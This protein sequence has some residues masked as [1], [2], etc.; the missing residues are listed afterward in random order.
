MFLDHQRANAAPLLNQVLRAIPDSKGSSGIKAMVRRVH[1]V[2]A[3]AKDFESKVLGE[4]PAT[5]PAERVA[6]AEV[7]ARHRVES[8]LDTFRN[9]VTQSVETNQ[10]WH[11][12]RNTDPLFAQ[13]DALRDNIP[14]SFVA[15]VL[16]AK[17]HAFQAIVRKIDGQYSLT[18]CNRGDRPGQSVTEFVFADV[19]NLR[20]VLENS[21]PLGAQRRSVESIYSD[22]TTHCARMP[23]AGE[24]K[25]I[26]DQP[27]IYEYDYIKP[28]Q[29]TGNCVEKNAIFCLEYASR[30]RDI[31][32]LRAARAN[33]ASTRRNLTVPGL[34]THIKQKI[35]KMPE[36]ASLPRMDAA[37]EQEMKELSAELRQVS[38][39]YRQNRRFRNILEGKIKLP[40]PRPSTMEDAL[41]LA[42]S[43][44]QMP[45]ITASLNLETIKYLLEHRKVELKDWGRERCEELHL[46]TSPDVIAAI[47]NGAPVDDGSQ[48]ILDRVLASRSDHPFAFAISEFKL[49][50]ASAY[51]S[52]GMAVYKTEVDTSIAALTSAIALV[53]KS[54][55]MF[56]ARGELYAKSPAQF[57]LAK[58][59]FDVGIELTGRSIVSLCARAR[60]FAVEKKYD[61]AIADFEEA[62]EKIEQKTGYL[63]EALIDNE[64]GVKNDLVRA[65]GLRA[66]T[67]ERSGDYKSS[68]DD[69]LRLF[70]LAPSDAGIRRDIATN[71][72]RIIRQMLEEDDVDWSHVVHS[73]NVLLTV[74]P[75][76]SVSEEFPS[77]TEMLRGEYAFLGGRVRG[78]RDAKDTNP[79]P[80]I[81]SAESRLKILH[82]VCEDLKKNICPALSRYLIQILDTTT[83]REGSFGFRR[84]RLGK[85]KDAIRSVLQSL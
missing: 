67:H 73:L 49:A 69:H 75:R 64:K 22:A 78:A 65:Y 34:F 52:R 48:R 24:G 21:N 66:S 46:M 68:A 62:V 55:G 41:Q 44:K 10:A 35:M 8:N 77:F 79:R 31:A 27:Q 39:I 2:S 16:R 70:R 80:L 23:G 7:C 74:N 1:A 15:V 19:R 14:D 40:E 56:L 83:E 54:P 72:P 18:F 45:K 84:H 20:R 29:K 42:F 38:D 57:A 50:L 25:G 47:E 30:T 43:E 17:G 59:D 76:F 32:Q 61:L 60:L 6:V 58:A 37:T 28:N 11:S 36:Q 51:N 3:D 53:P 12:N 85:S 71:F 81:R 33:V 26:L 5:S 63:N 4:L 9:S 82:V 13:I